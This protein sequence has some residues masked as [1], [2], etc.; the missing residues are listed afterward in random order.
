MICINKT[1]NL[2]SI[3]QCLRHDMMQW[4]DGLRIKVYPL[5][6]HFVLVFGYSVV[7][8]LVGWIKNHSTWVQLHTVLN[9]IVYLV[10]CFQVINMQRTQVMVQ[11]TYLSN[12]IYPVNI[13]IP[14]QHPNMFM[15][16]MN[17]IFV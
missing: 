17:T 5:V 12:H 8:L 10:L 11:G 7:N 15:E 4:V 1:N 6:H 16:I 2:N 3:N 13:N 9:V 14:L